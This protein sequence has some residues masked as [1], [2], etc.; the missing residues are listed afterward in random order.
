[1]G[2]KAMSRAKVE[3]TKE[4]AGTAK[5][6]GPIFLS[7]ALR[8]RAVAAKLAVELR[9]GG[10]KVWDP[11]IEILPG[12]NWGAELGRALKSAHAM[13]VLLSPDATDSREV[14]MDMSY[15]LGARHLEHRLIPV[16]LRPTKGT[17]WILE[18]LPSIRYQSPGKTAKRIVQLLGQ[19]PDAS[20]N[21]LTPS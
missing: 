12:D 10:L 4:S 7:Y 2:W 17:P 5:P 19:T 3:S 21:K 1:M 14:N 15:A 11:D 20:K 18:S 13:V 6:A 8:D 16:Y 9:A